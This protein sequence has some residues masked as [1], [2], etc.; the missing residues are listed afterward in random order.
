M[1]VIFILY[2]Y[3]QGTI[4]ASIHFRDYDKLRRYHFIYFGK[5][6]AHTHHFL[7]YH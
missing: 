1:C 3:G 5:K 4:Y 6:Y 7:H 2:I